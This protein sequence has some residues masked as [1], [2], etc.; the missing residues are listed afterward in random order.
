ML[1]SIALANV[2]YR[3]VQPRRRKLGVAYTFVGV[4]AFAGL[5]G[6]SGRRKRSIQPPGKPAVAFAL[7]NWFIVNDVVNLCGRLC[8]S[9]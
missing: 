9:V 5:L 8:F 7:Q 3:G 6:F 2:G 1:F 4:A